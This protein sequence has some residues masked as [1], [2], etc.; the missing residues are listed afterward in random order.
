MRATPGVDRI[1]GDPLGLLNRPPADLQLALAA[2]TSVGQ[3]T[4]VAVMVLLDIASPRR[5]WSRLVAGPAALR[6]VA[7]LRWCKVLGCGHEGGFGL[8]PS[9]TRQGLFCVFDDALLAQ[10]FLDASPEMA[11][12]RLHARELCSVLLYP[13]SSIGSWSGEAVPVTALPPG[14]GPVAALTRA[15]IRLSQAWPFWRRAPAAQRALGSA[16]GCRLAAGLGEAPL[17]RQATF[18]VWDSE[19]DM[20]AYARQGAHLA[21]IRASRAGGYFSEAMFV[22]FVPVGLQGEWKGQRFE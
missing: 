1:G 15:S 19:T 16:R 4:A 12:C 21:A 22:R 9:A 8:R 10:R 14:S 20:N 2:P 6:Q 11:A 17:L 3:Q 18:S 13:Y 5:A 7:G